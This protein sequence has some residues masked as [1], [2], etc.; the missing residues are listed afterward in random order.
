M[1]PGKYEWVREMASREGNSIG[2]KGV[3]CWDLW[4]LSSFS[5]DGGLVITRGWLSKPPGREESSG[6]GLLFPGK[7]LRR[8]GE[9][10]R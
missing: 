7:D 3:V 10:L 8:S 1:A 4:L 6:T 9:G 5:G 2:R